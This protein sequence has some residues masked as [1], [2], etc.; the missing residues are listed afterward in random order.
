MVRIVVLTLLS[1]VA[2]ALSAPQNHTEGLD[3]WEKTI[4]Y[5]IYPRSFKDSDGDGVG[6]LRG[7]ISKLDY[8]KELDIEG[9]WLSPVFK[10][11]MADFGYDISDFYDIDP[12]FGTLA[13]MEELLRKANDMGLKI[14]LDFVPNHTSEECEWFKKSVKRIEPYTD[15]YVWHDGKLNAKGERVPPNNWVSN[16]YGSAWTWNAERGQYYY[17]QFVKQQPD[18]NFRNAH[19]VK[20][21]KNIMLFWLKKG[22]AGFRVD[23]INFLFEAADF[24]DEPLSGKTNDSL[25][26]DYTLHHAVSDQVRT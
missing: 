20:E 10:S 8:L 1:M 12:T 24:R 26:Y 25:A 21:M 19:V 17:H 6:D 11:P 2:Y 9:A 4:F 15:Y 7:I 14:I 16:F 3:W 5:Q 13:D 23:A 18:L 22:A